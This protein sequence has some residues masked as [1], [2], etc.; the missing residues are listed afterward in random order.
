MS[1]FGAGVGSPLL[2][3]GVLGVKL[4]RGG[5]WM[6]YG[7]W[8]FGLLIGD[9]SLGYFSKGL[10]DQRLHPDRR[11]GAISLGYLGRPLRASVLP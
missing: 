7:Q 11:N 4:P 1:S 5:R 9:F 6:V 2:A 3:I 10:Q 8:L